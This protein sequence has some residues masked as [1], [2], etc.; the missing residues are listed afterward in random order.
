MSLGIYGLPPGV[1]GSPE[2]A[3]KAGAWL[4]FKFQNNN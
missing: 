2:S 1:S 3:E 4:M